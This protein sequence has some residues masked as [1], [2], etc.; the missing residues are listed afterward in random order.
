MIV[1]DWQVLLNTIN[2]NFH[3]E[4][5]FLFGFTNLALPNEQ[6]SSRK[7]RRSW[8]FQNVKFEQRKTMVDDSVVYESSTWKCTTQP[9]KS[10]LLDQRPKDQKDSSSNRWMPGENFKSLSH[11]NVLCHQRLFRSFCVTD[12]NSQ[13]RCNK[14]ATQQERLG[15]TG[16]VDF[17]RFF[18]GMSTM[19]SNNQT[20]ILHVQIRSSK[21]KIPGRFVRSKI[22]K[23]RWNLEWL[24][25][26]CVLNCCSI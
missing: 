16:Q 6:S 20:E 26:G 15:E 7:F 12:H 19:I 9:K 18:R 22:S 14:N 13:Y 8:N 5:G 1:D 11:I 21:G 17:F 25:L 10:R 3:F 23:Q 2:I 24:Q 4:L